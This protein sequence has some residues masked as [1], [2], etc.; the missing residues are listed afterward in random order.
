[1]N[2]FPKIVEQNWDAIYGP[3]GGYDSLINECLDCS[4]YEYSLS[5]DAF[6][7]TSCEKG[8]IVESIDPYIP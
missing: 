6:G 7:A 5:C 4:I 1:M 8:Y 3:A 2:A